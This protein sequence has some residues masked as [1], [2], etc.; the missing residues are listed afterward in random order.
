MQYCQRYVVISMTYYSYSRV[1]SW[2]MLYCEVTGPHSPNQLDS[3]NF[4][5]YRKIECNLMLRVCKIRK[6]DAHFGEKEHKDMPFYY[7]NNFMVLRINAT[8]SPTFQFH[9]FNQ[10]HRVPLLEGIL[11]TVTTAFS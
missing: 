5:L 9:F 4:S 1:C 7:K 8:I 11:N 2:T 10:M 6:P 3:Y